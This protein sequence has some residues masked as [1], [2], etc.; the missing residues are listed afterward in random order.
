VAF[1]CFAAA[2]GVSVMTYQCY[3]PI[4]ATAT[5]LIE[6]AS[7]SKS[8]KEYIEDAK[9]AYEECTMETEPD[10]DEDEKDHY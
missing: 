8:S 10:F 1:G 3:N 2:V 4:E 9:L 6:H 7:P 5:F